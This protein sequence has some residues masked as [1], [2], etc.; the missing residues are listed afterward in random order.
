[1]KSMREHELPTF[2]IPYVLILLPKRMKDRQLKV[3]PRF[4]KSSTEMLDPILIVSNTL[5]VDPYLIKLRSE[6]ELPI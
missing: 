2:V 4:R 3:D 6:N 5:A 1:M